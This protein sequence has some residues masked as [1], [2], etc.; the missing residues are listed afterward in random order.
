MEISLIVITYNQIEYLRRQIE[1][2]KAQRTSA[3]FEVIIVNDCS[4]DG[5]AD[6][7]NSL[8][9]NENWKFINNEKNFGRAMV[10]NIGADLA[11]GEILIFVDGDLYL[12]PNF[13]E[14]HRMFH[15]NNPDSV[16]VGKVVYE[17]GDSLC[18]YLETRGA[19][20]MEPGDNLPFRYFVSWN[21][22]ILRS[23]FSSLEGFDTD[24]SGYGGEDLEFGYRLTKASQ[25]IYY[26]EEATATHIQHPSLEEMIEKRYRFGIEALPLFMMKHPPAAYDVPIYRLYEN[27]KYRSILRIVFSSPMYNF[28]TRLLKILKIRSNFIYDYLLHGA[29]FRGLNDS[30]KG[31]G[32]ELNSNRNSI[33]TL[34]LIWFLLINLIYFYQFASDRYHTLFTVIRSIFG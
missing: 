13:L 32:S 34:S 4:S 29:V 1:S 27:K 10:R 16:A 21:F 8:Q 24:F 6:F 25:K 23:A 17:N 33:I 11:S 7:L 31:V 30:G 14:A 12:S 2:I 19:V 28:I 15:S 9:K 20:K 26:L 18:R 3:D 5:T 22:S